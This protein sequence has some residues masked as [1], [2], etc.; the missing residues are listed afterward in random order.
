[1]ENKLHTFCSSWCASPST[2]SVG[3]GGGCGGTKFLFNTNPLPGGCGNDLAKWIKSE[4][5]DTDRH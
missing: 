5:P 1:M 2:R 3:G 4:V